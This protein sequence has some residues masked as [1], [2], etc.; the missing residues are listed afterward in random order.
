MTH[1][2]YRRPGEA[3]LPTVIVN[4]GPDEVT[5]VRPHPH[6]RMLFESAS[7]LEEARREA[8][9]VKLTARDAFKLAKVAVGLA[10]VAF[11]LASAPYAEAVVTLIQQR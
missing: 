4:D 5:P 11:L 10:I 3:G 9:D 6:A 1:I 8:E 2:P 7:I